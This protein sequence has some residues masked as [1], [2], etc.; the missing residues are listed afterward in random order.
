MLLARGRVQE[1]C[2]LT[3]DQTATPG[4]AF[5]RDAEPRRR[6]WSRG[7]SSILVGLVHLVF[8]AMLTFS[9]TMPAFH[10]P[11]VL[12]TILMLPALNGRNAPEVHMLQPKAMNEAPPEIISAPIT[13]PKPVLPPETEQKPQSG[14]VLRAVGEALSCGAGSFETLTQ[15]ER[16]RCRHEPWRG[17]RLPNGNL[18][19]VPTSQ[20]PR[21]AEPVPQSEFRLSGAEAQRHDIE[22]APTGCPVMLNIPCLNN[23]PHDNN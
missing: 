13:L 8:L 23:I 7:L 15:T 20:M 14:D 19:M 16:S 2:V 5:F 18:V 17:G 4:F 21:L 10:R 3:T 11:S 9:I 22:V 6:I 1:L 12:E